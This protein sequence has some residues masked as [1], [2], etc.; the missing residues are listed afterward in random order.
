MKHSFYIVIIVSFIFKFSSS[1][2]A[3]S[4]KR[5][6]DGKRTLKMP[7]ERNKFRPL[8]MWIFV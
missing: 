5:A 6:M 4:T 2:Y 8:L 7:G 1:V 3:S